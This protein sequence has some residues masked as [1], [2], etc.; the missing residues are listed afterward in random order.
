MMRGVSEVSLVQI[1]ALAPCASDLQGSAPDLASASR[2]ASSVN[3]RPNTKQSSSRCT[4]RQCGGCLSCLAAFTILTV[5]LSAGGATTRSS[6]GSRVGGNGTAGGAGGSVAAGV[7]SVSVC[8]PPS[9]QPSIAR[10]PALAS[11]CRAAAELLQ[12]APGGR[13]N[14]TPPL[15]LAP[16]RLVLLDT[17]ADGARGSAANNRS[18]SAGGEHD[19]LGAELGYEEWRVDVKQ[20]VG[21][22]IQHHRTD[23]CFRRR[24]RKGERPH[25]LGAWEDREDGMA[26][27]L[28][29]AGQWMEG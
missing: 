11:Q 12:L 6:G 14:K 24:E 2:T 19:S 16:L 28:V 1:V 18:E 3:C 29:L 23:T 8:P 15:N 13:K 4:P 20:K 17:H 22:Y 10:I 26:S 7:L 21:A 27:V 25:Y 5:L 9:A